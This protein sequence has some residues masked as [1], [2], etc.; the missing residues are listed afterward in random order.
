M[1]IIYRCCCFSKQNRNAKKNHFLRSY[2]AL[3]CTVLLLSSLVFIRLLV[4]T[5][6]GI[7]EN[8]QRC[9]CWCWCWCCCCCIYNHKKIWCMASLCLVVALLIYF[10]YADSS[11]SSVVHHAQAAKRKRNDRKIAKNDED[12]IWKA[13]S[14]LNREI[15]MRWRKRISPL[16][17]WDVAPV[18]QSVSWEVGEK[19]SLFSF[20]FFHDQT[21]KKIKLKKNSKK[22]EKGSSERP[23]S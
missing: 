4:Y 22:K 18:I 11:S 7:M 19:I 20:L 5:Q 2:Y 23:I 16:A 21:R 17:P 14:I 6:K 13:K 15:K 10:H 9:C 3:Q 1:L 12:W 8:I